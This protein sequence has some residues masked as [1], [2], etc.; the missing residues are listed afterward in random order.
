ML[1]AFSTS[2]DALLEAP[3]GN[4]PCLSLPAS[5]CLMVAA[6]MISDGGEGSES[7]LGV[8]SNSR[9]GVPVCSLHALAAHPCSVFPTV[10]LHHI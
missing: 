4:L 1:C 3:E 2:C 7:F 10:S 5:R 8:V 9:L 6:D